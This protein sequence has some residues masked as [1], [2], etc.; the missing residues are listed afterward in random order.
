MKQPPNRADERCASGTQGRGPLDAP[1]LLVPGQKKTDTFGD[2]E[3]QHASKE[4]CSICVAPQDFIRPIVR[5]A[6][7]LAQISTSGLL[8][9]IMT[10]LGNSQQRSSMSKTAKVI[11]LSVSLAIVLFSVIGGLGVKASSQSDGAYKQLGVYSEVLSR[12]RSEYVEEP[13]MPAVTDGALHGL[14]E[15]LDANS[16][17]LD[18]SEYKDYKAHKSDGKGTIGAT[19]SKRMGYAAVV[20]VL[21]GG[22]ADK[23]GLDDGDILEAINGKT[24]REMSL[25]HI[26]T[27]LSGDPGSTVTVSVVRARRAEPVKAT[28]SRE[29]VQVPSPSDRMLEGGIGYIQV[30]ALTKGKSQEVA[31]RVKSLNKQGAKKLILDLRNVSEGDETEGIATANLFLNHGTIAYLEGQK[32]PRE[33]FNADSQKA[34]TS[35]PLVVLVNRGTAGAAE[36]I[37]SAVLE[38]A[39]GDVLGDKTFGMGAVQKVIELPDSSALILSVAKYHSPSG[40]TIQDTAVTP[41]IMVADKDD[42]FVLPDEDQ[43]NTSKDEPLKKEKKSGEDEQ[44]RRAIEVLKNSGQKAAAAGAGF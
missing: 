7:A 20:S 6:T 35:L 2:P 5:G 31:N 34:I 43:D 39:R 33:A 12:I 37:A 17:Y 9:G 24:T 18:P 38:N 11:V 29:V 1:L 14:L 8:S 32:Y 27:L 41:N 42:D 22:P 13:N 36:I 15:S 19:V 26:G 28:I 25:A 10:V 40:K 16:S 21:P 23:A 30:F 44:L 3:E 4:T